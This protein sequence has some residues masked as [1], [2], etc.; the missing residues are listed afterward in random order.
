MEADFKHKDHP[1]RLA[2]V[3]NLW[4]NGIDVPTLSTIYL[5][6]PLMPQTLMQAITR[7]NRTCEG[8]E[9]GLIVDYLENY[10][11]YAESLSMYAIVDSTNDSPQLELPIKPLSELLVV[12][13]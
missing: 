3:C 6:K 11:I 4:L 10:E 2:I 1:F 9:Y 12:N 13:C 8:K 7:A 5:D